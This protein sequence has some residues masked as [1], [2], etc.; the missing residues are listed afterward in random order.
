MKPTVIGIAGGTGSGKTF[1]T[2]KIIEMSLR[3]DIVVIEQ[4]AYYKDLSHMSYEERCNVNFDSPDSIDFKELYRD[5]KKLIDNNDADIPIYD[6][7]RHKRNSKQ[8][9]S[10]ALHRLKICQRWNYKLDN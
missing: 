8:L 6:Y 3:K 9:R 1:L 5:I 4:D 7:K 2:N 10:F